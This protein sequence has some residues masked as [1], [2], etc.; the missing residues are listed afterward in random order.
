VGD[1]NTIVIYKYRPPLTGCLIGTIYNSRGNWV[2]ASNLDKITK[3]GNDMIP[4]NQK[5]CKYVAVSRGTDYLYMCTTTPPMEWVMSARSW[6]L[7]C[8]AYKRRDN[9]NP[10]EPTE[11]IPPLDV[12]SS[13]GTDGLYP[14]QISPPA[15]YTD[16]DPEEQRDFGLEDCAPIPSSEEECDT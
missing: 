3:G 13:P 10:L 5:K 6:V 16:I 2:V 7:C 4:C 11:G 8:R 14:G 15:D 9:W 1:Y 12:S